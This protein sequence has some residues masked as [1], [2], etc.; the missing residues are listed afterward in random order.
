VRLREAT[1][2]DAELLDRWDHDPAY[3][4][5]EFNHF[6]VTRARRHAEVLA[7]GERLVGPA[8][9]TLLVE[10][11]DTAEV[12]GDIGWHATRYGPN[13]ES[14]AWNI[15]ISLIPTARGRGY[16][17]EAQRL[18]ALLLF[19]T[20]E[21]ARVEAS[22][23]VENLAEQQALERAGFVRE[24]VLR[25]AQYREGGWHD[26]VVFSIVRSDLSAPLD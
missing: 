14:T 1:K 3:W 22:T 23:D 6:G 9:G 21:V 25:R 10:R 18:V 5:G 11:L 15:G 20:T 19:D 7:E 16:G 8:S 2:A 26:L 24:G 4:L 12:I 13:D 17:A